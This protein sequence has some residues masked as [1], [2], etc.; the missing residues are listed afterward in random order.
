MAEAALRRA[1]TPAAIAQ[2]V[3]APEEEIGQKLLVRVGRSVRPTPSGAAVMA[4]GRTPLQGFEDL[5]SAAMEDELAGE[6]RIG[7]ISTALTG[8]LPQTLRRLIE[9]APRLEIFIEPGTSVA[10]YR[11][12]LLSDSKVI[13]PF[14]MDSKGRALWRVS[15]RSPEKRS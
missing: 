9:T 12:W 10:L 14:V 7:S 8:L 4:R 15:G 13:F 3:Q 11:R 1:V 2:R 5:R 6:I